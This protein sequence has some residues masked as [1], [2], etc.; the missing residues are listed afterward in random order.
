M[1]EAEHWM[2]PSCQKLSTACHH[3]GRSW[4]LHATIM[5]E[6]ES[7]QKLSTACHHHG[8]SWSLHAT[9]MAEAEHCMP[10]KCILQAGVDMNTP[11]LQPFQPF[12]A[13]PLAL[14]SKLLVLLLLRWLLGQWHLQ[15]V[16]GWWLA[17]GSWVHAWEYRA[18]GEHKY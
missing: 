4:A 9:I 6:A 5:A 12:V 17:A 18:V 8:R 13:H 16:Q 15:A 3:H 10:R 1:S 2:P 11:G 14:A 7:W